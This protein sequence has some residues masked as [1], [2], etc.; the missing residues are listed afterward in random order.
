[1]YTALAWGF[2]TFTVV[3]VLGLLWLW[4]LESRSHRHVPIALAPKASPGFPPPGQ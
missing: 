4:F 1:M 3:L 2:V